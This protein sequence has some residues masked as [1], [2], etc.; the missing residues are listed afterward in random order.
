LKSSSIVLKLPFFLFGVAALYL[1]L[2]FIGS[3]LSTVPV[4]QL[5]PYQD[6]LEHFSEYF[7]LGI[8]LFFNHRLGRKV[9]KAISVIVLFSW[10]VLDEF[11]QLFVPMR[12]ASVFDAMADYAGMFVAILLLQL[13]SNLSKKDVK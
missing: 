5:I 10:P 8:I 6:K 1:V 3:S 2:I 12:D 4:P 13:L 11:H 9:N 7:I